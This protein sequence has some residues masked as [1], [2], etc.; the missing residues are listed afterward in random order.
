M[1]VGVAAVAFSLVLGVAF[2]LVLGVAFSLVL[3]VGFS[4]AV[5][6]LVLRGLVRFVEVCELVFF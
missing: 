6:E 1:F 3:G 5:H 2:S 4:L